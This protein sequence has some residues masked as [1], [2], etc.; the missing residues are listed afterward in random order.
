MVLVGL[1]SVPSSR[2][3]AATAEESRDL[4]CWRQA[5]RSLRVWLR[6]TDYGSSNQQSIGSLCRC[7]SLPAAFEQPV[8]P[9]VHGTNSKILHP[10][11]LQCLV[12]C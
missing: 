11:K 6:A 9:P 10:V 12:K 3:H 5:V 8:H 4:T 7:R 2:L 1:E